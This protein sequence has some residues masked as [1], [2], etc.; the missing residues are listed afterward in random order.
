M[1]VRAFLPAF[2]GSGRHPPSDPTELFKIC[3]QI[4]AAYQGKSALSDQDITDLAENYTR[5]LLPEHWDGATEADIS[6]LMRAACAGQ[7]SDFK[8]LQEFLFQ[9][10]V[11]TGRANLLSA[12][13]EGYFEGWKENSLS[14]I[15]I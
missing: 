14:L 1:T 6:I 11:R 4:S 15:H 7:L 12:M 8:D 9:Q 3:K 2:T 10:A 5:R 13:C